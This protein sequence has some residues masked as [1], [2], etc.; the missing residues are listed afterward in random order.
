MA[1]GGIETENFSAIGSDSLK[2]LE[3][4]KSQAILVS[5]EFGARGKALGA[6]PRP[7]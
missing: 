6:E 7:G 2:F 4:L 1:R 5:G 3:I